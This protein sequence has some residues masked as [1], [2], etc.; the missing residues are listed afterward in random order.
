MTTEL[1]GAGRFLHEIVLPTEDYRPSHE[2]PP[3]QVL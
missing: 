2:G 1:D 3:G